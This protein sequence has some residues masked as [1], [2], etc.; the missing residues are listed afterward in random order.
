M[1]REQRAYA[2]LRKH[3]ENRPLLQM[4]TDEGFLPNSAFPEAG[5]TLKSVLWRRRTRK[6]HAG[7]TSEDLPPLSY[8]R[9]GSVAIRELVPDSTFYAQGRRVKIDQID[10]SL[11]PIERWR[12]CRACSY[13]CREV[14]QG[15]QQQTCPRCG[16]A[17]F[18]DA[19]QV[20]E[21]AKLRQVIATSDDARTRI[22]DDRDER[23]SNFFQRQLLIQPDLNRV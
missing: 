19:H 1:L 22:A 13:S 18:C 2:D 12:F 16:D 5:V 9:P 23:G 11:N 17:N 20:K 7:R 15:F 14:D 3:L 21:M 10:L 8:E 4:L 6:P